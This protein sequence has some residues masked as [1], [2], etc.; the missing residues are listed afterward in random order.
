MGKRVQVNRDYRAV[1]LPDGPTPHSGGDLVDLTNAE[2]AALPPAL[3][4]AVTDTGVVIADPIRTVPGGGGGGGGGVTSVAG[5]TGA[6]TLTATDLADASAVGV[7]VITAPT[8]VAAQDSL[9]VPD[10]TALSAHALAFTSVQ[11]AGLTKAAV[12]LG[13]VDNTS[14]LAK[15][16]S[17]ATT[18]ALAGK[19]PSGTYSTAADIA[20]ASTADRAR[21]NHTGTQLA[22]TITGLTSASVGLAN[23]DNTSDLSKPVSTAVTAALAALPSGGTSPDTQAFIS[24]GTWTKPTGAKLVR[25]V[26][27]GAGSGGGSGRRGAASTVRVGGGGGGAGGWTQLTYDAADLTSTVSVTVGAAGAGG[28]AI[29]V[30][31]TSGNTGSAGT[32]S[33]FGGYVNASPSGLGGQGGTASSGTGGTAGIGMFSGSVGGNAQGSGGGGAGPTAVAGISG[34]GAGGG[35]TAVNTASTGAGAP[36]SR[37]VNNAGTATGGLV[38][39]TV[40]Q[41]AYAGAAVTVKGMPGWGAGG[42]ASSITTTAQSGA[43]ALDYGAGGGG[44]GAALNGNNSGA[45]GNGGG[46]Y[47]LVVTTF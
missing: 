36:G 38:D 7:A 19:Q 26:C 44:G 45:G 46:G 41:G 8:V 15:P 13:S 33:S 30:N 24:S 5:R 23:V 25:V 35:I 42:G 20:T 9:D 22:T 10:A 14:D 4:R 43:T 1:V 27:I 12:G 21:S 2:F 47:V 6:V 39:S 17:T 34:G 3:T 37:M 29:T 11:P 28:A 32:V 31:D 18:T 16:V 40:P